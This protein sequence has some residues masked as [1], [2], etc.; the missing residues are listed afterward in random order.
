MRKQGH[1]TQEMLLEAPPTS[2]SD[3][4]KDKQAEFW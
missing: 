3:L 2:R 1:A 4:F